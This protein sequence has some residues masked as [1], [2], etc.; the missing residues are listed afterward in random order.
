MWGSVGNAPCPMTAVG[1]NLEECHEKLQKLSNLSFGNITRELIEK[2]K[3]LKEVEGRA[4]KGGSAD[5][6]YILKVELK[7]LLSKEEKLWQQHAMVALLKDRDQNSSYFHSW[8]S[9]RFR[10]NLINGLWKEDGS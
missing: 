7:E 8:T 4:T 3:K 6:V 9:H 2:K 5:M 10:C 1:R